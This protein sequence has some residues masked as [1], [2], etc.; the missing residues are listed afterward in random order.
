[1]LTIRYCALL[2]S[3]AQAGVPSA[4]AAAGRSRNEIGSP[5]ASER[6]PTY[7]APK[8]A[9]RSTVRLETI[10]AIL[11]ESRGHGERRGARQHEGGLERVAGAGAGVH[12]RGVVIAEDLGHRRG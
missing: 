9:L 2:G 3:A 11:L 10:M 1:M 5:V 4:F 8:R 12:R 6:R 7:P